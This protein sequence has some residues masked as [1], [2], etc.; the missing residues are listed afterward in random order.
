M[1]LEPEEILAA[2][3]LVREPCLSSSHAFAGLP[4]L[5]CAEPVLPGVLAWCRRECR[6]DRRR[7]VE[8]QARMPRAQAIR[9][10]PHSG[11]V[12]MGM[13]GRISTLERFSR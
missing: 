9:R 11:M 6:F 1:R 7:T 5:M 2:G 8:A 12:I 13:R 4:V 3:V 10:A